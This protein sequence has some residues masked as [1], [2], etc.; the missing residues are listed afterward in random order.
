MK[1]TTLR[2]G[3]LVSL[4]TSVKGGVAYR[5]V[6]LDPEHETPEGTQE[7]R[8]ETTRTIE[9]PAEFERAVKVRSKCRSVVTAVCAASDF[10][11]LCPTLREKELEAA[12]AEARKIA[13]EF[14]ASATRC[15]IEVYTLVGRVASDDAE[16]ARAINSEVRELLDAME[17]GAKAADPEA[18]R[19]AA[20]RARSLGAML[21]EEAAGKVNSAIEQARAAA[22]EIVK[23]VSKAGELAATVA[24][25]LK[26]D[27]IQTA[28]FAF[29]DLDE[30]KPVESVEPAAR[31]LDLVPEG[32]IVAPSA[33]AA[34]PAL[35]FA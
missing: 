2:P 25:E 33:P 27:A 8:W 30:A 10:G 32:E 5:R 24:A 22:R 12:T 11:L 21:T 29:L 4:K 1:T 16:A 34:P 26:V 6:D 35:D 31:G 23:R 20:N 28:R 17:A 19:A 3:L 7:A 18:I 14:N 15:Q 13:A 9:D